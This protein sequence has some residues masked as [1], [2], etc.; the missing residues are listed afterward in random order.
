QRR[1]MHRATILGDKPYY[2]AG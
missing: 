1:I 2:R